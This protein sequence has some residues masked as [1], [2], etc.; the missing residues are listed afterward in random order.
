MSSHYA[1]AV[2]AGQRN[3][4]CH[5][6]TLL[7]VKVFKAD[8]YA[9]V[10]STTCREE[11][12]FNLMRTWLFV[13]HFSFHVLC[14][15]DVCMCVC[16]CFVLFS[17]S[18]IKTVAQVFAFFLRLSNDLCSRG[19]MSHI[20]STYFP[21]IVYTLDYSKFSFSLRPSTKAKKYSSKPVKKGEFNCFIR[22]R[23]GNRALGKLLNAIY[24]SGDNG[25]VSLTL[26]RIPKDRMEVWRHV[27]LLRKLAA[28]GKKIALEEIKSCI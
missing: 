15:C 8:T 9:S 20:L 2:C 16:V 12:I 26:T 6:K 1:Y 13:A 5:S 18:F 22:T 14:N 11:F 21:I 28:S 23:A 3:S 4:I 17:F 7:I 19:T 10:F 24:H 25:N 27:Q